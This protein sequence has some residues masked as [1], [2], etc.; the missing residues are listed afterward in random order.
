[1]SRYPTRAES[2]VSGQELT[3]RPRSMKLML[4]VLRLRQQSINDLLGVVMIAIGLGMVYA[5]M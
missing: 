1:M 5:A 3:S 4:G 2:E